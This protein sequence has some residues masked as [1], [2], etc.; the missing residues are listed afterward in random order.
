LALYGVSAEWKCDWKP[1]HPLA[2]SLS[3]EIELPCSQQIVERDQTYQ[4]LTVAALDNG[5][6]SKTGGSHTVHYDS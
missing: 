3:L 4:M 6:V 5:K 2:S 1:E